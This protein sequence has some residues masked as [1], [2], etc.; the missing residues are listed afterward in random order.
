MENSLVR[1]SKGA[2]LHI[3]IHDSCTK[4]VYTVVTVLSKRSG[5]ILEQTHLCFCSF[6]IS[7]SVKLKKC[8]GRSKCVARDNGLNTCRFLST[9]AFKGCADVSS[10]LCASKCDELAAT[11]IGST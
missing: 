8:F 11:S 3:I 2:S 4:R 9:F 6:F 10:S 7:S 5:G 1:I